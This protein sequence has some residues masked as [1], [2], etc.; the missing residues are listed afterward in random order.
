MVGYS[1]G[2]LAY[3]GAIKGTE[4]GDN[5]GGMIATIMASHGNAEAKRA[6]EVNLHLDGEQIA[7]VV[8]QRNA[9]TASR[10]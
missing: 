2:T 6:I 4:F 9:R 10:N 8:N 1:A 3:Q 5:I 7:T